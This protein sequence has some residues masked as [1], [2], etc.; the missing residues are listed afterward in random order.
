MKI[1]GST[2]SIRVIPEWNDEC[3]LTRKTHNSNSRILTEALKESERSISLLGK[4]WT[5][6]PGLV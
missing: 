4:D 2:S 3:G 6:T 5:Q 1:K